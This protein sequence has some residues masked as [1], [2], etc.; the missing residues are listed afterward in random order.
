MNAEVISIGDE[1]TSGARL[2][3]NSRWISQRLMELGLAVQYHTTVG[4]DLGA[5]TGVFRAAVER[6]DVVVISGGLGPTADDLTREAIAK[7][8]ATEL[9]ASAEALA[10]I[11]SRFARRGRPMPSSNEVQALLPA[12]S[13]MVPNPH[14][15][16]PG[17]AMEVGRTGGQGTTYLVALPGVPSELF[18]MWQATVGD[19][20]AAFCPSGHVIRR[21]EIH[22]FGAGESRIEALLPDL[23]RRGRIP[24]VGIT[25]SQSTI[26]LRV[27]A[28]GA[29]AGQCA[30][31]MEPT[32]KTIRECLG[33]LVFGEG[34][35]T[36]QGAVIGLLER[37]RRTLA[38]VEWGTGGTLAEWLSELVAV[39]EGGYLGGLT[40]GCRASASR[41]LAQIASRWALPSETSAD[42]AHLTRRDMVK[43]LAAACRAVTG[44]DLALATGPLAEEPSAD[45]PSE[46]FYFAVAYEVGVTVCEDLGGGPPAMARTRLAKVALNAVRLALLDAV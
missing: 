21:H 25:A 19:A 14:G 27:T 43:S 11:H 42:A 44:A 10:V 8:T 4:D 31:V 41:L 39:G 9:V 24:T 3:T 2:D 1:L 16:A 17:I 13:H 20:I 40:V 23:I 7:A 12:G 22:C 15:T 36:L 32:L 38:T 34:D 33:N 5:I 30:A 37:S 46:P 18:E 29:T 28:T 6:A 26:T 35:T 45:R